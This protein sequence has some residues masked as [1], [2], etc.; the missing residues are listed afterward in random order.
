MTTWSSSTL[1]MTN[2]SGS[3]IAL[4]LKIVVLVTSQQVNYIYYIY[5]TVFYESHVMDSYCQDKLVTHYISTPA[6]G[7]MV[8]GIP[9][10]SIT[11][12]GITKTSQLAWTCQVNW[13]ICLD[14][15]QPSSNTIYDTWLNWHTQLWPFPFSELVMNKFSAYTISPISKMCCRTSNCHLMI[16]HPMHGHKWLFNIYF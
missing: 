12:P 1:I 9:A 10:S 4:I 2:I 11:V 16:F 5:I 7:K 3:S 15:I 6:S 14:Q 13:S 8:T